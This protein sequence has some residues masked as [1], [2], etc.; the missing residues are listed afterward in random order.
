MY[1]TRLLSVFL[2]APFVFFA[3]H[4]LIVMSLSITTLLV[5]ASVKP[6]A[7]SVVTW[8]ALFLAAVPTYQVLKSVW[9]GSSAVQVEK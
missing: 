5:P 2:V 3:F 7:H 4:L 8:L 1:T 9:L 6:A